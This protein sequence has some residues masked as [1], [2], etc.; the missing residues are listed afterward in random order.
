MT[1]KTEVKS[2]GIEKP[3]NNLTDKQKANI[4][5]WLKSAKM[6]DKTDEFIQKYGDYAYALAQNAMFPL[7]L[8][9]K[10]GGEFTTSK[11]AVKYLLDNNFEKDTLKDVKILTKNDLNKLSNVT[12]TE[13]TTSTSAA[14]GATSKKE[15]SEFERQRE[16]FLNALWNNLYYKV[17]PEDLQNKPN[18]NPLVDAQALS[19]IDIDKDKEAAIVALRNAIAETDKDGSKNIHKWA[20]TFCSKANE[21]IKENTKQLINEAQ[22]FAS[23]DTITLMFGERKEEIPTGPRADKIKAWMKSLGLE[24]KYEA[25][26]KK[27][28]MGENGSLDQAYIIAQ[29]AMATPREMAN[30]VGGYKSSRGT[31]EYLIDKDVNMDEL[32]NLKVLKAAPKQQKNAKAT[33]KA[34]KQNNL[35]KFIDKFR[36][37]CI[38]NATSYPQLID[39]AYA[40]AYR[41]GVTDPKIFIEQDYIGKAYTNVST[42]GHVSEE[43]LEKSKQMMANFYEKG[44]VVVTPKSQAVDEQEAAK[45]DEVKTDGEQAKE[46]TQPVAN[47]SENAGEVKTGGEQAKEDTQPVVNI[48]ENDKKV[49]LASILRNGLEL[50]GYKSEKVEKACDKAFKKCKNKE[51]SLYEWAVGYSDQLVKQLGLR[52]CS[53]KE[54]N[55]I[56][57]PLCA[58]IT[59]QNGLVQAIDK[60]VLSKEIIPLHQDYVEQINNPKVSFKNKVKGWFTKKDKK[61]IEELSA[62]EISAIDAKADV[63]NQRIEFASAM[64]SNLKVAGFSED[65]IQIA[66]DSAF[67]TCIRDKNAS[68]DINEWAGNFASKV[69]EQL[70]GYN[71]NL[72]HTSIRAAGDVIYSKKN[73]LLKQMSEGEDLGETHENYANRADKRLTKENKSIDKE[74]LRHHLSQ[75]RDIAEFG[76]KVKAENVVAKTETKNTA[77]KTGKENEG[78]T[79][80]NSTPIK[81]RVDWVYDTDSR[82]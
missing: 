67:R 25:F 15:P 70:C 59:G 20:E 54:F 78:S 34:D 56:V 58:S 13:K 64:R 51:G 36:D 5:N 35:E 23:N 74:S 22:K 41:E 21:K 12:T 48:S 68:L 53:D 63:N 62:D 27:Y 45:A 43:D 3:A 2:N 37:S 30:M 49:M 72:S 7:H 40:I 29:N 44:T 38:D 26:M 17:L 28:A 16:Q 65:E 1:D 81:G 66:C 71:Q 19:G 52:N 57:Q 80:N 10:V 73:A 39:Y 50:S 18:G 75:Q 47:I 76:Y 77:V 9:S 8:A 32:K 4:R 82:S 33:S 79:P 11:D 60:G 31:I 55:E 69:H 6:E 42:R 46:D 14:K 61:T 24:S